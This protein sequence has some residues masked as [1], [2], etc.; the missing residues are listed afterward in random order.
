MQRIGV[1]GPKDSVNRIVEVAKSMNEEIELVP[2][3]YSDVSETIEIVKKNFTK[4]GRLFIS[5]F[6]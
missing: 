5:C 1:I 6:F 4:I 3:I 2:F